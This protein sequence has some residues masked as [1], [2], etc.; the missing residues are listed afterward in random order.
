MVLT[1]HSLLKLFVNQFQNDIVMSP[2]PKSAFQSYTNTK[3][4]EAVQYTVYNVYSS[5]NHGGVGGEDL[6][7]SPKPFLGH[8]ITHPVS[9]PPSNFESNL[10]TCTNGLYPDIFWLMAIVKQWQY[11]EYSFI[12]LYL[13][14]G[15]LAFHIDNRF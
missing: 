8:I 11:F 10:G 6:E 12:N 7:H 1:K 4:F 2:G 14:S 9:S 15:Y 13:K 3:S 5:Q